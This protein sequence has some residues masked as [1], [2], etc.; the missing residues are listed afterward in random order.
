MHTHPLFHTGLKDKEE[1]RCAKANV[2]CAAHKLAYGSLISTSAT[3]FLAAIPGNANARLLPALHSWIGDTPELHA[4]A[5]ILASHCCQCDH[6]PLSTRTLLELALSLDFPIRIAADAMRVRQEALTMS[7]TAGA[8]HC[9][10]IGIRMCES[11][12]WGWAQNDFP[13]GNIYMGLNTD[14]IHGMDLGVFPM[15]LSSLCAMLKDRFPDECKDK[16]DAINTALVEI[17]EGGRWEFFNIP[18]KG[19]YLPDH[20]HAQAGEHRNVMQI[21]MFAVEGI[22]GCNPKDDFLVETAIRF[23][24]YVVRAQLQS[25]APCPRAR[26]HRLFVYSLLSSIFK[27]SLP[28]S[29]LLLSDGEGEAQPSAG[30]HG[31]CF[32]TRANNNRATCWCPR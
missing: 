30:V 12:F 18:C 6:G 11:P 8:K 3:G 2:I 19:F 15:F 10:G 21:F 29:P 17:W 13:H 31:H 16:L 28:F 4:L 7:K 26:R 14:S 25:S 1:W 5:G 9:A 32:R 20:P 24:E 27:H 23:A 22:L